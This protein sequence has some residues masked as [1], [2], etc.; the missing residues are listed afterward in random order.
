[1]NLKFA[2]LLTAS[3][4]AVA[5]C[6]PV[7]SAAQATLPGS[8][9][10]K[11]SVPATPT[12]QCHFRYDD[13]NPLPDPKCTPGAVQST[14]VTAICSPGW[15]TLHREYFTKAERE[16][17]F[18]RYGVITTNPAGYGEYDHLIPLELGGANTSANLW[19]EKGKIPNPKDAVEDTLHEEVCAGKVS[20][21]AAQKAIAANWVTAE[22]VVKPAT[23]APMTP[24]APKPAPATTAPMTPA[25]PKPAPATTAPMTPAAPKPAPPAPQPMSTCYPETSGGSCYKAGEFCPKA[26]AG[27]SGVAGDGEGITCEASGSRWRWE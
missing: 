16:T 13:G 7:Q 9:A 19:P 18:A 10:T 5:A 27:M 23:T 15:A 8:P 1:M 20:L 3:V 2:G 26:D 6:G 11:S 24:A 4:A 22:A 14:S 21:A 25:A 12:V 17:A